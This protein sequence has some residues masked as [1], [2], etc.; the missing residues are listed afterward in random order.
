MARHGA[1]P[2]ALE[3]V[4]ADTE[5]LARLIDDLLVLER[6]AESPHA[7]G[8]VSLDALARAAAALDPRVK[9]DAPEPVAADGDEEALR[10]AVENLVANALTHGE[11]TV[12]VTA[13]LEGARARLTVADEG[14]GLDPD[15][16]ES[17]FE[18]FWRGSEARGRPGSGLGLA[19]VR[20]I[21]RAHGGDVEVAGAAFTID[22]PAATGPRILR[23]SSEP[24]RSVDL[25][26]P[27][28]PS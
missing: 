22:L 7:R 20:A 28:G 12:S 17:A 10:R 19:I 5:R 27:R 16:A 1:D 23:D 15:A 13:R 18:R 3:D 21:A 8:P 26:L 2:E 14:P 6:Q 9:S 24:G 25:P 4:R 11:G